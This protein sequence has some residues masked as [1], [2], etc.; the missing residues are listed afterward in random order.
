M[1]SL[2]LTLTLA[3]VVTVFAILL[4]AISW[5]ITGKLKIRGGTCGRDPTKK[6]AEDENCGTKTSC[7][8]C[9]NPDDKEK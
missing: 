3:F 9:K 4:L 7:L 1:S 2:V 6:Q 8:L 5:L